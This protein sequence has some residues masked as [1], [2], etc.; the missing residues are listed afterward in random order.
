LVILLIPNATSL[1]LLSLEQFLLDNAY[2]ITQVAGSCAGVKHS[3]ETRAKVSAAM[4]GRKRSEETKAKISRRPNEEVTL[5]NTIVGYQSTF[6][7]F[8]TTGLS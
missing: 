1:L 4:K 2:N 3:E 8:I 7:Q 6:T 5:P